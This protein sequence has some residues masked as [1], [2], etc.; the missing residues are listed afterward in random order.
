MFSAP[1]RRAPR[2]LPVTRSRALLRL[3]LGKKWLTS[4][5]LN[6]RWSRLAVP[7]DSGTPIEAPSTD[8]SRLL[9][10]IEFWW[11]SAIWCSCGRRLV[12]NPSSKFSRNSS[13]AVSL[14]RWTAVRAGPAASWEPR[15]VMNSTTLA[16]TLL[17]I[18]WRMKLPMIAPGPPPSRKLAA[19]SA[20]LASTV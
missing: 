9:P 8:D 19:N 5:G 10:S 2:G 15:P 17:T 18:R 11:P 4:F 6:T 1:S 13:A 3:A 16:A 12:N 7:E 20:A 14:A